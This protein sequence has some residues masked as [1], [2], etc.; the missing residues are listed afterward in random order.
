MVSRRAALK[1]IAGSLLLGRLAASGAGEPTPSKSLEAASVRGRRFLSDLFDPALGL[2]PEYRGAKV[3][4]LY[5]DN[6]LATKALARTD[7]ALAK[8]ITAAIHSFGVERSGKI[9]IVCGEAKEPL[10][11]RRY[12]LVEVKREGGKIIKTELVGQDVFRGWEEYADLLLLAAIA[13]AETDPQQARQH[14]GQGMRLW[15]GMGFGDRV[16][17]KAGRYAVYKVALALLAAAKM[18]AWPAE[19]GALVGRLLQQ[20]GNDGGWVTDYDEKGR[21]LGRANVETTALAVLALDAV[22]PAADAPC[23]KFRITTQR[24]DDR[25]EVRAGKDR[26]LFIV[27][28]PFGISQAV[29]EREGEKWPDAA[30]LRLHLKGLS[31]FRASNGRVRVDAAVSIQEGKTQV[32]MWK[33]GKEGA[34]LDGN[35]PLWTDVSIIGGDG[36]PAKELPLKDGYFEV[37]LPKAFFEGNP[38]SI[39]VNWIDIYRN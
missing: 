2:L 25:V 9:E 14:F 4:W 38:K 7:P 22:A 16:A 36:K 20:Q 35:S 24:K 6:Y 1:G 27:K 39:T 13:S 11:F 19:Q 28:S 37:V 3:Y 33:D 5:H 15:D 23:L 26:T 8:K 34:P 29:I 18:K 21:P 17:K 30:V 31:N 12:R 10:P 32:R